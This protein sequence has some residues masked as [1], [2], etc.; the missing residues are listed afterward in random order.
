MRAAQSQN[1]SC[2]PLAEVAAL[3]IGAGTPGQNH[4]LRFLGS[5]FRPSQLGA[6]MKGLWQSRSD[7]AIA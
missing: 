6:P 2:A 7:N 5:C 4:R 3:R 1:D